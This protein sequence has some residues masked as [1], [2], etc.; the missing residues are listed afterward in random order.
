MNVLLQGDVGAGKTLVALHAALVAIDSGHQAAI[1]APT[2]VLAG[3]HF[4]SVHDLLSR[5]GG[6]P[7]LEFASTRPAAATGGQASLLDALD[8]PP[9][10]DDGEPA[11]TYALLTGAVTA[12]DR[13]RTVDARGRRQ[14]RPR[15][16]YPCPG[17][18][19]RDVRRSQ[20]RR[21]R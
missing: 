15:R 10:T 21:G 17:A 19:E 20:P 7:Y 13:Q 3:Q 12:K 16:R 8:G 14:R 18:G 9:S 5:M 4:R 1:M 6:V 2:E 11:V